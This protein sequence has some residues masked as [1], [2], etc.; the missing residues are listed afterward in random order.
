MDYFD[1][2]LA[3]RRHGYD[4]IQ[5]LNT[6]RHR[7]NDAPEVVSCHESCVRGNVTLDDAC[8]GVPKW[9]ATGGTC[10]CENRLAILNC[11]AGPNAS[12]SLEGFLFT[13][14]R[15]WPSWDIAHAL[16]LPNAPASVW[17]GN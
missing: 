14:R 2:C 8:T 9:N 16:A 11:A 7:G 13:R 15:A 3:A 1:I 12:R 17:G 5:Y 4:T 10:W 6:Y